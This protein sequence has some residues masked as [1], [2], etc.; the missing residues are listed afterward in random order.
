MP[1]GILA[2]AVAC[3]LGARVGGVNLFGI[4]AFYNMAVGLLIS[5]VALVIVS[6]DLVTTSSGSGQREL[7]GTVTAALT[8]MTVVFALV[9][10]VRSE[11][12]RTGAGG[13]LLAAELLALA[14]GAVGAWLS[15]GVVI[16][17]RMREPMQ[18][19]L[20][21]TL[22]RSTATRPRP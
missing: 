9:W 3:D 10:S 20:P 1:L 18:V 12:N 7:V 11:G 13:W 22:S 17:R 19:W 8:T 21:V 15:Q 5:F 4:A 14:V 2:S 6:V 16:G